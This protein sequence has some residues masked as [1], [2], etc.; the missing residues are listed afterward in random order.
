[1]LYMYVCEET[2][3]NQRCQAFTI[4]EQS[5]ISK[6][7]IRVENRQKNVH[8]NN[9]LVDQRTWQNSLLER[10]RKFNRPF[11]KV[12]LKL[13]YLL[14]CCISRLLTSSLPLNVQV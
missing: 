14:K 9:S 8:I 13:D 12:N 11:R 4:Q 1:M 6:N 5:I 10:K 3:F 7:R 2:A